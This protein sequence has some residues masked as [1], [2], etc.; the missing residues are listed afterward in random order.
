MHTY[1]SL[2]QLL[3]ATV[4]KHI[5]PT[6]S[7]VSY[8]QL[9]S[10]TD[11]SKINVQHFNLRLNTGQSVIL[12][13]KPSPLIERRVL[14]LLND[15]KQTIVPLSH[16]LD[17]TDTGEALICLEDAGKP[18]LPHADEYQ[19]K[20]AEGLAKIHAMNMGKEAELDWLPKTDRAY[21]VD[22]ILGWTWRLAWERALED[23]NFIKQFGSYIP[24][25]QSSVKTFP[26]AMQAL[27]DD[28]TTRT[29]IHTDIYSGHVLANKNPYIIDWGQTHYG[30]F[31]LDLPSYFDY[32][33]K[34]ELYRLE[35]E[36]QGI[37][38]NQEEFLQK[39]HIAGRF[40]GF[41][42]MWGWIEEWRKHPAD[43]SEQGV[44]Y[45]LQKAIGE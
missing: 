27:F 45:M 6:A 14:S 8:V 18:V 13:T 11:V 22:F 44:L 30:S 23:P 5:N 43:W 21:F 9:P 24:K 28:A 17:L 42:Y 26:D 12:I 19:Q 16:S 3:L 34:A 31:Y 15:Q 37:S 33:S 38:I 29:L 36:K 1:A 2:E 41:R 7:I 20:I 35:L 40:V 32:P 4:Q 25:V 10:S 39:Y